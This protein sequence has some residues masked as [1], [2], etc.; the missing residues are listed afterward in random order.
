MG[1]F[2]M[3]LALLLGG[4]AVVG[5]LMLAFGVVLAVTVGVALALVAKLLPIVLLI[6]VAVK[7]LGRG[8]RRR[9]RS[10]LSAADQA[11]LDGP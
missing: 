5:V 6:W 4:A 8:G 9:R 1:M 3:V 11:W 7:L 10:A 2:L